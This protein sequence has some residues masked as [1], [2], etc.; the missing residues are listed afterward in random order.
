MPLDDTSLRI[1]ARFQDG[2]TDPTA[3]LP[4][5]DQLISPT[6]L[7]PQTPPPVAPEAPVAPPAPAQVSPP[8]PSA[9][10]SPA[11]AGPATEAPPSPKLTPVDHDPFAQAPKPK[12]TPVDF[13]PFVE[14]TGVTG[15]LTSGVGAAIRGPAQTA[16]AVAGGA[17]QPAGPPKTIAE[18]PVEL[19]DLLHP[20]R[21]GEKLIYGIASQFPA[22]AA[23]MA[24]GLTAEAAAA[25]LDFSV[26][27]IPAAQIIAAGS[28][29]TG[30]A[31]V[32][33]AQ[34]IGPIF[35]EELAKNPQDREGAWSRT[36][37]TA[38]QGAVFDAM[39]WTL[40]GVK[41]FEGA[42]KNLV[43]QAFA[44]QPGVQATQKAVE[45]VEQG[46]PVGEG[47]GQAYAQ[48]VVGTAPLLL[49]THGAS[50]LA[51]HLGESVQ[52]NVGD[53]G[54][55][56]EAEANAAREAAA[57]RTDANNQPEYHVQTQDQ[58]AQ[59]RA[60]LANR[61]A[62]IEQQGINAQRAFD[63]GHSTGN[64][65]ERAQGRLAEEDKQISDRLKALEQQ[66]PVGT[67]GTH[68]RTPNP[69]FRAEPEA[70]PAAEPR[71]EPAAR[72]EAERPAPVSDAEAAWTE[73]MGQA[74][75]P[76]RAEV[77]EQQHVATTEHAEA[78]TERVQAGVE[79]LSRGLD[80]LART[81]EDERTA[82][83]AALGAQHL[84]FLRQIPDTVQA[85]N[86]AAQIGHTAAVEAQGRYRDVLPT[87]QAA[88]RP[89]DPTA[90]HQAAID[91]VVAAGRETGHEYA[92]VIDHGGL[93]GDPTPQV[94]Y[95]GTGDHAAAIPRYSP[96]LAG[97][98]LNPNGAPLD[99][100]HVHPEGTAASSG[101]VAQTAYPSV[102]TVAAI[103]QDSG[104]I[105]AV[106]LTPRAKRWL[107]PMSAL[108][109]PTDTLGRTLATLGSGGTPGRIHVL[110]AAA[111][112]AKA[113][114]MER[115]SPLI[116]DGTIPLELASRLASDFQNRS[117][118]AADLIDYTTSHWNPLTPALTTEI[119][120]AGRERVR[121]FLNQNFPNQFAKHEVQRGD[122]LI[123]STRSLRPDE[124]MARLS[125]PAPA[126]APADARGRPSPARSGD[127]V[128]A[129]PPQ[130]PGEAPLGGVRPAAAPTEPL[131]G[132]PGAVGGARPDQMPLEGGRPAAAPA[133]PPE[134]ARAIPP[135]EP[136]P[137]G[138]PSLEE[139]AVPTRPPTGPLG[140][141]VR[142][143][144][145]TNL[146]FF[147]PEF[148]PRKPYS[149]RSGQIAQELEDRQRRNNRAMG[150]PG[151]VIDAPSPRN[152]EILARTMATEALAAARRSG[153]AADWYDQNVKEGM[154]VAPLLYPEMRGDP[155]A[156][157]A[158][159]MALAITS[160]GET[161]TSNVRLADL[162]Y[163]GVRET[164][165]F[166]TDISASKS[167][168][169]NANFVKLN[170]LLDDYAAAGSNNPMMDLAEF[171]K[172]PFTVR[173]LEA[174]TGYRLSGVKKDAQVY[175]SAILGPKI[176]QGFYQNLRGN[177]SPVTYDQWWMQ[178]WGRLTGKLIGR[179]ADALAK[180]RTRFEEALRTDGE[181][182]PE[183]LA[184]LRQRAE[185]ITSQHERDYNNFR[186][187]YDSGARIKSEAVY[188]A[189]RY[190]WGLEGIIQSPL[191]AGQREWMST[192]ANRARDIVAENGVHT[193]NAGLQALLWY[194][195]KELYS[196]LGG[197]AA[198]ALTVNYSDVLQRLARE[199]GVSDADIEQALRSVERRPGP[200][201]E[202][203]V[204]SGIEAAGERGRP[205]AAESPEGAGPPSV[206][207]PVVG[208]PGA[209]GPGLFTVPRADWRFPT[210][211][212]EGGSAASVAERQGV[213]R[214]YPTAKPRSYDRRNLGGGE[215]SRLGPRPDGRPVAA[216]Y[217]PSATTQEELSQR[218]V[219][220]PVFQELGAE[221]GATFA[222]HIAAVKAENPFGAAVFVYPADAYEDMRLFTTHTGDAGFA[223]KPD[224]DIVSVFRKDGGP[225]G[226]TASMLKLAVDEGGRKLDAF[227]TVLPQIYGD[228]GFKAVS[229]LAWD[230]KE[231]PADW[232]KATFLKWNEG[233]PDVVF[234]AY[235]PA[236]GKPY[237]LGDGVMADNYHDAV[238]L[239]QEAVSDTTRS[240]GVRREDINLAEDP[241]VGLPG[242]E[243]SRIFNLGRRVAT[244]AA[245]T[246]VG[247]DLQTR[248]SPLLR[249]VQMKV[250]PMA[251]GTAT[252]QAI[253]KDFAN[254]DR[255]ARY[256][257][258][259]F[260]AELKKF[261]PE[262]RRVMWETADAASVAAQTSGA[263]AG[264]RILAR[265]PEDQRQLVASVH[266][267]ARQLWGKARDAGIVSETAEG[268]P[269]YTTRAIVSVGADGKAEPVGFAGG[270]GVRALD[271]LGTNLRTSG[272]QARSHLTVEQTLEA[273]RQHFP[274]QDIQIVRD[275]RVVPAA[276][277]RLERAIAGRELV[278][279]IRD[280]SGPTGRELVTDTEQPGYFT[281]DHPAL[282][283]YET[284]YQYDPASGRTIAFVEK[285]P[286]YIANDFEGPLR[287]VLRTQ[288]GALYR[289]AIGLKGRATG[290]I[291]YSPLIH[292]MVEWGRALPLMPGK[293]ATGKIYF[294]GNAFRKDTD[295][296]REAINA[297]LV[298]IGH[299][300]YM[301]DITG[302]ANAQSLALKPQHGILASIANTFSPELADRLQTTLDRA[303][304]IWHDV[305]LWDRVAD[306]QAGLYKNMRDHLM[307][308]KGLQ[309][310]V[311]STVAAHFANRY[312]GALPNEA[313]SQM[314]QKIANIALFSRTFKIGNLG[315][316]KD[317]LTGLPQDVQAQILRDHG[318]IARAEATSIA[319]RKAI[320]TFLLD[321]GL[322]FASNA[323]LQS[324][325]GVM[326]RD[327]SAS[328]VEKDW[329]ST[330]GRALGR[331]AEH[332]LDILNPLGVIGSFFPPSENEPGKQ[333]RALWT[334]MNDG[335]ALYLRS[336]VGK[337]GEEFKGWTTDPI[338]ML[339]QG[340]GTIARPLTNI[341][342]NDQGFGRKVYDPDAQGITGFA[343]N[344]GRIAW[345]FLSTQIPGQQAED[346]YRIATGTAREGEPAQVLA[347]LAGFTVSRGYPG[348]PEIGVVEHAKQQQHDQL[349]R[350]M[351]G[352]RDQI[353]T[354][355]AGLALQRMHELGVAPGLARYYVRTTL[356]PQSR[357]TPQALRQFMQGATPEQ[358]QQMSLLA[359]AEAP[360][361]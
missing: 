40:F 306:L 85:A 166:P 253:A 250:A 264:A 260:D 33:A 333:D 224:G 254:A 231:K 299:R 213:D 10:P 45:N 153:H 24:A 8:P 211:G 246:S 199:R 125:E 332:P 113:G 180:Q 351:P 183:T 256:Q 161:V 158:F 92:A 112:A 248:A 91:F 312:A 239:Q 266:D 167:K 25:P 16:Q 119:I 159:T 348:G 98:M 229:R 257:R 14:D 89:T 64:E 314:S 342:A 300:A 317:M 107:R 309:S 81:P 100:I 296:M 149:L 232:D 197:R 262:Q 160:Q 353:R 215:V 139:R 58:I 49:G 189:D 315:V 46:K 172:R 80:N 194:P 150:I 323:I 230:E 305:L 318:E 294:E 284:R 51:G 278:N 18:Q 106:S 65:L 3:R 340:E 238:R 72:P 29:A 32:S 361:P 54:T 165:R 245:Q 281:I 39:S 341:F 324:A 346:L 307:Q 287:A 108:G 277:E 274:D 142:E 55:A 133:A 237:Q 259:V 75:A 71:A 358:R 303:G 212:E 48:G 103:G 310:D 247:R 280:L 288:D 118:H 207:S 148:V 2:G 242:L 15:A 328:D 145:L 31:A 177:F 313:M 17:P 135:V 270:Q 74:P 263:A 283:R 222:N 41:P 122:R 163:R 170:K 56:R 347:P 50:L 330:F 357:M 298:P 335:T 311:A 235:D 308:D 120:V 90:V 210:L 111:E 209:A 61:Q 42:V 94:L 43:L 87:Y 200:A 334:K 171:L 13:D 52:R 70:E 261:T 285:K 38:G 241:V 354:G 140:A 101:D 181:P 1:R 223:I 252:T 6:G 121:N 78:T 124:A 196:K 203:D 275:M 345:Q 109:E 185:E 144:A 57:G 286:L 336:P 20:Y 143:R 123:Q 282:K 99:V 192:V 316:M 44:V 184:G 217:H 86:Q 164:G 155:G 146:E 37:A 255:G 360:P 268:L 204:R 104:A 331:I 174:A 67:E 216:E 96:Q 47:V 193:T 128:G 233:Q 226:A 9:P 5:E 93:P 115:M 173:E 251:T 60:D 319:K 188:A 221:S 84:G 88:F 169:M 325:L 350:E 141:R 265:L 322:F 352:L 201:G 219:A 220:A 320:N 23:G 293:V 152:N 267:Y 35:A 151:G 234:M 130:V 132:A 77:A 292:N 176:G 82:G 147:D 343:Q 105:S 208:E 339:R 228:S 355:N 76:S 116:H 356:Y 272:V 59:E 227:D 289:A 304:H 329:M 195:E 63:L 349:M 11:P 157:S 191:S 131:G 337:V 206:R 28:A 273:A 30:Y 290:L 4:D 295:A 269:F 129:R 249:D 218:G 7:P 26:V 258:N 244:A 297:G 190:I 214:G 240:G 97:R 137:T 187:D 154:A 205:A 301:Q 12:L 62:Y 34:K 22:I 36:L 321:I 276:L 127:I 359:P 179:S 79:E 326:S 162:V 291:M 271:Q 138:V 198:Q 117:L 202:P 69:L 73:A 186:P 102:R 338:Q 136:L 19:G 66:E 279:K 126:V 168:A 225:R 327:Q 178:T 27:G 53:A 95:A 83:A 175:G 21:L 110:Y 302:I 236:Y 344:L 114:V 182:V 156:Q 243:E 134:E 68:F